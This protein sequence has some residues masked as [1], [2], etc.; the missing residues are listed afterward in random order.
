MTFPGF[1]IAA[2]NC[3]TGTLLVAKLDPVQEFIW[4]R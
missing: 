2:S 3:A 4:Q 1:S